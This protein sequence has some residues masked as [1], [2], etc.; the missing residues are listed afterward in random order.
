[1]CRGS[2]AEHAPERVLMVCNKKASFKRK[3]VCKLEAGFVTAS[4]NH[5]G[6]DTLRLQKNGVEIDSIGKEALGQTGQSGLDGKL[7]NSR[8][9]RRNG[10]TWPRAYTC[11]GGRKVLRPRGGWDAGNLPDGILP[12]PVCPTASPTKAPTK[13]PTK[14]PT[15]SPTIHPTSATPS[16]EVALEHTSRVETQMT[17]SGMTAAQVDTTVLDSCEKAVAAE[18]GVHKTQVTVTVTVA[19]RR[20]RLSAAEDSVTFDIEIAATADQIATVEDQIT[21]LA[22]DGAAGAAAQ[23]SFSGLINV[24]ME[25]A[26]ET[27]TVAVA[28]FAAPVVSDGHHAPAAGHL[29]FEGYTENSQKKAVTV[30]NIGCTPTSLDGYDIQL[31]QNGKTVSARTIALTGT[32]AVGETITYCHNTAHAQQNSK[33]QGLCDVWTNKLPF[34]GNDAIVL[35]RGQ[36]EISTIGEV[37]SS[38]KFAE[39]KNCIRVS[40]GAW[41]TSAW[42]CTAQSTTAYA[43]FANADTVHPDKCFHFDADKTVLGN[44][45]YCPRGY[46]EGP[47][48]QHIV[49]ASYTAGEGNADLDSTHD[50]CHKC[51]QGETSVGGHVRSCHTISA[52]WA[53]C[54][55][56]A[57]KAVTTAHK[58][59]SQSANPSQEI[60]TIATAGCKYNS[61]STTPAYATTRIAVFHH[62]Q[63]DH[64]ISHKC[65]LDGKKGDPFA[66]RACKCECKDVEV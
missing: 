63:E 20:R 53:T 50:T 56:L 4:I 66:G 41:G 17:I 19:D 35:S 31:Y 45:T 27:A 21:E 39:D 15:A 37:G 22:T 36:V 7:L 5:N 18:F 65:F 12:A 1:M 13:E 57:C 26:G 43:T 52:T 2:I 59:Y 47:A 42:S 46:Y 34:N 10:G 48:A 25:Q 16:G 44:G 33:M 11:K 60:D 49:H 23:A 6:D 32:L 64:G 62:G 54:S 58:C 9:N 38:A 28:A 24:Y 8:C 55:H 51:P 14:A 61:T 29:T 40:A 3:A 30:R